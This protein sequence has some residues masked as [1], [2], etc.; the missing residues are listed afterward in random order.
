MPLAFHRPRTLKSWLASAVLATVTTAAMAA[1]PAWQQDTFYRAGD[2]VSYQG[3]VY[4]ALVNQVN[5]SSSNWN[6]T[7][8]SLWVLVSDAGTT[9]P[10]T[11][12]PVTQPPVTQPPVTTPPT[13][14]PSVGHCP[15][16]EASAT[17]V[18]GQFAA[19]GGQAYRANWWTQANPS[20]ANGPSG[21][22]QPWTQ[23][24]ASACGGTTPPVT[25]PPVTQPPVTQPPVTQPPVTQPPV[26]QPPVKPPATGDL[27]PIADQTGR[28][29]TGYYMTWSAPWFSTTG[30]TPAEIYASSHFAR[31]PATY[32]HVMVSFAD[33]NF[34]WKGLAANDWTGSGIQFNSKPSDVKDAIAVLKQR[35]I[36][37]L[38]AVGGATYHNWS[39]LAA[40]GAAGSGPI[41]TALAKVINDLG[42]DGLDVDY[43]A[44]G[45]VPRYANAIRAMRNAVKLAGGDRLLT[46]ATWSTG[47]DCIAATAGDP[48][49]NGKVSYWGGS[50]GRERVLAKQHPDAIAALDMINVMTYD[51]RFER[52]DPVLAY[53]ENRALF[54]AKTIVSP[55]LQ[56]APESWAGAMLVVKD[57]DA[58]CV[59]SKVLQDQYGNNVDKPYSVERLMKAVREYAGPNR[60]PRDGAMIWSIQKKATGLCGAAPLASPGTVGKEVATQLSLPFDPQLTQPDYQ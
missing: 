8:T 53:Q 57:A 13:T 50:A 30:K 3:K 37:V 39:P 54:P 5:Y 4:K 58:Q 27:G 34:Q 47:A 24:A 9:P 52:Y 19:L 56:P 28:A 59:G 32:T 60:N 17:Y 44:D 51:A 10:V 16:W 49:C 15:A 7:T 23:V 41:T 1:A 21:S 42:F 11:Q 6:P 55:G 14:P 35:N 2:L 29:Y 18:G 22:G 46:A 25:Q 38:L 33:P 48:A 31:M 45:D 26:T 40:E 36:K 12:P 20:T 43:E